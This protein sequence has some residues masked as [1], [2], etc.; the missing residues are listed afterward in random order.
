MINRPPLSF[1]PAP[2]PRN[3]MPCTNCGFCCTAGPCRLAQEFL[4]CSEG[5]CVALEFVD[6]K[7]RCG[8]VRNPLGYLYKAAHPQA[9]D[10]DLEEMVQS[11]AGYQLSVQL[12]SALGLGM[13]C[14]ADDDE[15]SAAWPHGAI[16]IHAVA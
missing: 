12:A 7:S 1:L 9:T 16:A 3:G 6:G 11:D 2:K 14:D 13:G 5:P 4:N 15:V 8:L 10:C